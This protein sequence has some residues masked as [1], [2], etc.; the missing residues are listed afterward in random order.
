[1]LKIWLIIT[2]LRTL[3][4]QPPMAV[5]KNGSAVGIYTHC[6]HVFARLALIRMPQSVLINKISASEVS[7][8][9][10]ESAL[11][12]GYLFQ[13]RNS[14]ESVGDVAVTLPGESLVDATSWRLPIKEG[15]GE[16][17]AQ[18]FFPPP[19]P[20]DPNYCVNFCLSKK[21][22]ILSCHQHLFFAEIFLTCHV[23]PSFDS[24]L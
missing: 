6:I 9:F 16:I 1:M 5:C 22:N 8:K 21:K 7:R 12:V 2:S 15:G 14:N 18:S 10:I 20:R 23:F 24:P 13:R 11:L 3:T 17:V 4:T 19:T